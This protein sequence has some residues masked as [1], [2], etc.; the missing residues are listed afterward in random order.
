[1]PIDVKEIFSSIT[2]PDFKRIGINLNPLDFIM[3]KI[4]IPTIKIR[5]NIK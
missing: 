5:S 1:M 3:K 4:I 2:N